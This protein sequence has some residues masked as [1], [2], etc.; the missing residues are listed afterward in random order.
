MEELVV[1]QK[2][3]GGDKTKDTDKWTKMFSNIIPD[4]KHHVV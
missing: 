3:L 1:D 2:N 4:H